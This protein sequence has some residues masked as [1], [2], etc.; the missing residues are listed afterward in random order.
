[1]ILEKQTEIVILSDGEESQASIGMSLDLDSAQMLMQMLSK[2]LYSDGIG[3]TIR[4][5]ASNALDSH[6]RAGVTDPIIV[7]LRIN[8]ESNYEFTVEDFGSG[9]DADDVENIISKYGKSTKRADANALGMFGL[10]FKSPLAYCSSFFFTCRKDGIER[11]YMMY[12]GEDLNTIDLLYEVPT[13]ERNGVKVIVPIKYSDRFDFL[14]K[15]KEQLAYFESVYFDVYVEGN[16]VDN[17]FVISR[18]D[19]FQFS[20]L[21]IDSNLHLCLDNVYYPLDFSKLG[22]INVNVPVG[23]RFSLADGIFPTPNRE[24]LRYTPEAIKTILAKIVEVSDYFVT[25]FNENIKDSLDPQ[26]VFN[27]YTNRDKWVT[28][29]FTKDRLNLSTLLSFATVSIA[30][31]NITGITH[32]NLKR[33]AGVQDTLFSEYTVKSKLD[34]DRFSEVKNYWNR[35][36]AARDVTEKTYVFK[37]KIGTLKKQYLKDTL[38]SR[39][40]YNFIKKE[41]PYK[42][43]PIKGSTGLNNYF[44]MLDLHAVNKNLWRKHI[45][46]FQFLQ[47]LLMDKATNLDLVVV[48]EAWLDARK[49]IAVSLGKGPRKAKL[50]GEVTCKVGVPLLRYVDGKNSK[51][52]PLTLKLED[53]HKQPCLYVYGTAA[54]TSR[55]DLLFDIVGEKQ[56]LKTI[57]FSER[58]LKV[59]DK[60]EIHNLMSI[61][62][63]MEGKNKIFKRVVTASLINDL[64]ISFQSVFNNREEIRVLSN[65]LVDNLETLSVYKSKNYVNTHDKINDAMLEV[66]KEHNLFDGDIYPVYEKMKALLESLPFLNPVMKTMSNYRTRDSEMIDVISDL[67]KYYKFRLD[68]KNYDLVLNDDVVDEKITLEEIASVEQLIN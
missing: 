67:L 8:A 64:M 3:S 15:T 46:E 42:L 40:T 32:L 7:G 43:F 65:S 10:G 26:E 49:K 24:S 4:E 56:K 1:M 23:L 52:E 55:L 9:L 17:S 54:D 19:N 11:K 60:L 12:E 61:K 16:V 27:Y 62:T 63:F 48:P 57:V 39:V 33:L 6:R 5:T 2:N 53:I 59:I 34:N 25:K 13:T 51:L 47:S 29:G 14:K 45:E 66:A 20:E 31:P 68:Y 21:A 22:I 28:L 50:A 38:S 18:N 37:E 36:V 44:K 41:T 35:T 30:T 58:E